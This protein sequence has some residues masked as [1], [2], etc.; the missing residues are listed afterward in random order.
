MAKNCTPHFN[1]M[2]AARGGSGGDSGFK[3]PGTAGQQKGQTGKQHPPTGDA[4][5]KSGLKTPPRTVVDHG[6]KA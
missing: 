6:R 4:G 1:D 5:M 2:V 3:A